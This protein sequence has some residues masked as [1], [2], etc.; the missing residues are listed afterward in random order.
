MPGSRTD[1]D[2]VVWYRHAPADP[3]PQSRR[4]RD[5]SV[6]RLR[7][8]HSAAHRQP[9]PAVD[10]CVLRLHLEPVEPGCGDVPHRRSSRTVSGHFWSVVA[11]G[12]GRRLGTG[13]S[14]RFR[15]PALVRRIASA[16]GERDQPARRRPLHERDDVLH[17]GAGG[18]APGRTCRPVDHRRGSWDRVCLSR[19][20][21]RLLSRALSI[22]LAPGGAVDAARRLGRI[23]A[24]RRRCS[25]S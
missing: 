12:P 16:A 6:G 5:R 18:F 15:R 8:G 13:S 2:V 17:T 9:A 21:D 20:R 11:S 22:L 3:G 19:D 23:P 25:R 14:D 4:P 1:V 10:A 7:N 24:G